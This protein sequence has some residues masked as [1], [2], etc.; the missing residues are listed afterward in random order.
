MA[1]KDL[2]ASDIERKVHDL[3]EAMNRVRDAQAD[4]D[5]VVVEMK[6][7]KLSRLELLA[8][9]LAP[10]F[11]DV[12]EEN[13]TFEFA[14]TNGQVP[15]LWIDMTSFIRMAADG[16]E[17]E[18]VKDTRMG[19][20]ILGRSANR[21]VVGQRV[22]DYIA[23][24]VLER[25]RMIEGDWMSAKPQPRDDAA[26]T[27]QS[28]SDQPLM[29][30]AEPAGVVDNETTPTSAKGQSALTWFLAGAVITLFVML[31]AVVFDQVEPIRD[32]LQQLTA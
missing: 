14:I 30:D 32:W 26:E 8:E 11:D 5:D 18:F 3:A 7:A 19:R 20:V 25:E 9:D 1:E 22:T 29:D 17:Y 27:S 4:R 16:R 15:R 21:E 10:V 12:P 28:A 13:E 2:E 24:R 31:L 23:E 6:H